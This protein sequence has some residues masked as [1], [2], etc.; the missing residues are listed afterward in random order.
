M[1]TRLC[2]AQSY[3][4]FRAGK[5]STPEMLISDKAAQRMEKTACHNAG[6]GGAQKAFFRFY[7]GSFQ[8]NYKKLRIYLGTCSSLNAFPSVYPPPKR[9]RL[10]QFP[11][12]IVWKSICGVHH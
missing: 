11:G 4:S 10:V 6:G 3:V 7:W 5:T 2:V 12:F 8:G 9:Y 1:L